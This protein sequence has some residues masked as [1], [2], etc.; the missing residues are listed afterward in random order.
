MVLIN[1]SILSKAILQMVGRPVL[2]S[3]CLLSTFAF[4]I[5]LSCP[6][7]RRSFDRRTGGFEFENGV[8]S[9]SHTKKEILVGKFLA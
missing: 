5:V 2:F 7:V 8:T 6:S 4:V 1:V 9:I 3:S